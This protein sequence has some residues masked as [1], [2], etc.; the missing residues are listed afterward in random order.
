MAQEVASALNCPL[1]VV[2]VR[3]LGFPSYPEVAMGAVASFGGRK[4]TH[5]NDYIASEVSEYARQQVLERQSNEIDR[6]NELYRQHLPPPDLSQFDCALIVD[7][8]LATG[9]TMKAAIKAL[10]DLQKEQELKLTVVVACPVGPPH[11]VREMHMLADDI[12]VPLVPEG[13][14][15]VGQFYRDFEQVEDSEV[16]RILKHYHK[17]Q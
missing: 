7:D 4:I 12:V 14:M 13:F 16:C 8:G 11:T 15:G 1:D 6:R 17:E 9:A 10:K 3:K 2:L 5:W